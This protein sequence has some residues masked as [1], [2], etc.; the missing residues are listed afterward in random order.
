MEL[1]IA[2][3]TL[4]II[5]LCAQ[6]TVALARWI[7]EVKTVD[8]RI[9]AFIGEIDSLSA[10]YNALESNL[11]SPAMRHV[12]LTAEESAG[13]S[14]WKQVARSMSDCEDTMVILHRYLRN[15]EGSSSGRLRRPYKQFKESIMAGDIARLRQRIQFFN[16]T[17]A[18]P[19]QMLTV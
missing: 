6:C 4:Q 10:T 7:G 2:T 8:D 9:E 3:G 1:G 12:A 16:S 18:L 15:I 5:S 13:G 11:R 19:L 17:L 14:L